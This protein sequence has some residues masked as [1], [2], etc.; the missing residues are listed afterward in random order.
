M[1]GRSTGTIPPTR[2][3][4][5]R[6]GKRPSSTRCCPSW[7]RRSSCSSRA[8]GKSSPR[9]GR[10]EM[11]YCLIETALG[12]M[13]MGWTERGI[14][15][16]ALPDSK[17]GAVSLR[18]AGYGEPGVPQD[19]MA[20]L[21]ERV[22][23]YGGGT[24]ME[25]ADVP[26]DFADEPEFHRHVYEHILNVGWGETTTYGDIARH[27]GDVQLSRAVGMALGRNPIPL[28]VPCHR[29]LASNGKAGG[30]SAPGGVGSKL[31]MLALE[32]APTPQGQF[33][34]GF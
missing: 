26:L 17:P 20:V 23:A 2:A 21:V 31:K 27:L 22:I 33:S 25:F 10:S 4:R 30:F 15:R 12:T 18:M 11:Q 16:F 8:I 28:I 1:T 32:R 34:F 7:C 9:R 29:V 13:G 6:S 19:W 14:A 24:R 5:C 3:G